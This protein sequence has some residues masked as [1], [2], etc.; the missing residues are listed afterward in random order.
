MRV[1]HMYRVRS[2][3]DVQVIPL[4]YNKEHNTSVSIP[5]VW[6]EKHNRS[7]SNAFMYN[8]EHNTSVS[9]PHV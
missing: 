1:Y 4:M 7:A 2:I 9:I 6:S 8:E 3:I 5:H